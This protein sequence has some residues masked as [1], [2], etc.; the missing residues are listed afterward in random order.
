M[1]IY[2]YTFSDIIH[3]YFLNN[4]KHQINMDAGIGVGGMSLSKSEVASAG[5]N[6]FSPIEFETSIKSSVKQKFYPSS[7]S[8]SMG[9][10]SIS[11]PADPDK[12]SDA[13]S[14]RLHGRM[15][16]RK[17]VGST[18]SDLE[19]TDNMGVVDN[20]FH[21]LWSQIRVKLNGTEITDPTG[22]IT[23]LSIFLLCLQF[24][25]L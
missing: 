2:I 3:Y 14:I 11:V 6:V 13:K 24:F 18:V 15:R 21:S 17:K 8:S 19:D 25:Y 9:P 23:Y 4:L 12:W 20:I 1:L 16:I 22:L 5:F 7:T 10:F